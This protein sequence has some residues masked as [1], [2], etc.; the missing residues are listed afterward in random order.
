MLKVWFLPIFTYFVNHRFCQV[1]W[2]EMSSGLL[3][4][5]YI[6]T[7]EKLLKEMSKGVCS[8]NLLEECPELVEKITENEKLKYRLNILKRS[9]EQSNGLEEKKTPEPPPQKIAKEVTKHF[10]VVDYGD[11][12]IEKLNNLFTNVIKKSFPSWSQPVNIKETFNPKYGDYQFDSCFQNFSSFNYRKENENFS[13]GHCCRN[14][15]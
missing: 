1:F 15:Y 7:I 8:K 10:E 3:N 4:E 13:K 11:S 9:A 6:E 14:Y 2:K 12:I 5:A